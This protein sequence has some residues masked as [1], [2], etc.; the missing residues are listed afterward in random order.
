VRVDRSV[1]DRDLLNLQYEYLLKLNVEGDNSSYILLQA[2]PLDTLVTDGRLHSGGES[3]PPVNLWTGVDVLG[4]FVTLT[5]DHPEDPSNVNVELT[6]EL[7]FTYERSTRRP[8][9]DQSSLQDNISITGVFGSSP[10]IGRFDG[11]EDSGDGGAVTLDH[12]ADRG[13]YRFFMRGGSSGVRDDRGNYMEDDVEI[14]FALRLQR[15]DT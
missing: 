11:F 15:A 12:L 3:I 2:D 8:E 13:I 9:I 7:V 6:F 1:K 10:R 4:S 14:Y 5:Y